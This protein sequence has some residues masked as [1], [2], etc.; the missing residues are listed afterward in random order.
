[1][2]KSDPYVFRF[3][4][5]QL[6]K[7]GYENVAF[8]GQPGQNI[9]SNFINADKEYFYDLSLD[10]WEINTF[11]YN[12][13]TL[14]KFDL[15]VCT[16]C[17]YFSKYPKKMLSEFK[18]MLRP[19]GVILIDWGLGDHWRFEQFKVGWVKNGEHEWAYNKNNRLW[20]TYLSEDIKNTSCYIDFEYHCQKYIIDNSLEKTIYKEVPVKISKKNI[21]ELKLKV[22]RAESLFLWPQSPQLYILLLLGNNNEL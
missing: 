19:E 20:S 14:E 18:S 8:F 4:A 12:I 7:K 1:M 5:Q 6:N 9:F 17:A 13:D 3:Y 11:P 2:G 10:N 16:R 22:I 15:I 21:D